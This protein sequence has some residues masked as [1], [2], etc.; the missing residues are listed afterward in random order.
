MLNSGY[1][2]PSLIDVDPFSTDYLNDPYPGHERMRRV[3]AIVRFEKYDVFGMAR[4]KEV[5]AAM[6]DWQTYS[7]AAG[8]GLADLRRDSNKVIAKRLTL[9]IDPPEHAKYRSVFTRILTPGVTRQLREEFS[10]RAEELAEELVA[11]KTFD[12]VG[13]GFAAPPMTTVFLSSLPSERS[14]LAG[15]VLNTSR[16][17]GNV[18]GIA[19]LG[20][21]ITAFG[22]AAMASGYVASWLLAA[23]VLTGAHHQRCS[24]LERRLPSASHCT[25]DCLRGSPCADR[26]CRNRS[27][28]D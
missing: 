5:S 6:Q 1:T 17:I 4:F 10:Q 7:S 11:R 8:V 19:A 23:A 14:G 22:G 26:Q 12:A 27:R 25:S 21:I 9:E 24:R 16:Q 15:G 20:T 2:E 18:L 3:G 13:A 28:S